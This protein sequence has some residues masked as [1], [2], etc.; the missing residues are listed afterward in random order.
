VGLTILIVI[1]VG[2]VTLSRVDVEDEGT[3]RAV[4]VRA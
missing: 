2:Y 4:A 1:L 3:P